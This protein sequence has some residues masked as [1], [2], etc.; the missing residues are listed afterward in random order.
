MSESSESIKGLARR[1]G[2]KRQ[3]F[4]VIGGNRN[5]QEEYWYHISSLPPE[6]QQHLLGKQEPEAE[7]VKEWDLMDVSAQGIIS[8]LAV[9]IRDILPPN[10]MP[11]TKAALVIA[12]LE[13]VL[14]N[15]FSLSAIREIPLVTFSERVN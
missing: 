6:T 11:V 9:G 10:A 7:K 13:Q 4:P 5:V 8:S 2:W 3:H 14:G 15:D 12:A 1:H